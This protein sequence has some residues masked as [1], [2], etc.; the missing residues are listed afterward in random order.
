MSDPSATEQATSRLK[1]ALEALESAMERRADVDRDV[2]A[3]NAQ[4]HAFDS[5]RARLAT[6]LDTAVARAREL[7]SANRDV[8]ERLDRAIA[9]IRDVLGGHEGELSDDR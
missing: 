9:D 3:L 8:A 6:E 4:V 7:E 5:D 2:A 1:D